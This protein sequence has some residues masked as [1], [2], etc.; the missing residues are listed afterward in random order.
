MLSRHMRRKDYSFVIEGS[1]D[2]AL[3]AGLGELTVSRRGPDTHLRGPGDEHVLMG[4]LHRLLE[5]ELTL[6]SL[7][8][9]TIPD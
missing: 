5:H 6:V 2:P 9:Q 3:L 8:M 1:V 7:K 4:V